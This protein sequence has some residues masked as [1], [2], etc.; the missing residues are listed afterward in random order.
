MK[1]RFNI[2]WVDDNLADPE[3]N[4]ASLLDRKLTR[5][6]GFSLSVVDMY[7]NIAQGDFD[8]VLNDLKNTI[9]LSNSI[10]LILVDYQL[11]GDMTGEK[12]SKK[13]RDK[14][15]SSDIV[16]YS[17][18]KSA[19][20]LRQLIANENIDG[21]NCVGRKDLAEG[22]FKVI[23]N[24]INRSHKISTLRGLILNSVCEMDH[25][26]IEIICKYSAYSV[27]K[28]QKI[29]AKITELIHPNNKPSPEIKRI[30]SRLA[31]SPTEALLR[32]K[33]MMSGKLFSVLQSIDGELG[34]SPV[35]LT[36]LKAYRID[37]LKLRITAAHS[38]EATCQAS[39]QSMLTF[40]N[41][42]YKRRDIDAIC[43]KIVEHEN[44]IS[45]ILQ[46]MA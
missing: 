5:K 2:A 16:F 41:T 8:E 38:K 42:E 23:E 13:F 27:A 21:V 12:I 36:L 20:E 28:K 14:L 4:I 19:E 9:D 29:N 46:E 11:G 35:K 1:T 25:M 18:K 15:P 39:G 7:E 31:K 44:N 40:K 6:N 43:K 33:S 37:I 32:H 24:I 10:D 45:S 3:M 26:I 30:R 17:G 34:L 22:T